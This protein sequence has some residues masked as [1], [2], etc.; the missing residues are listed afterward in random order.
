MN[1]PAAAVNIL[2]M[3]CLAAFEALGTFFF[4][5]LPQHTQ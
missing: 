1:L 5:V 4:P 2:L 3:L